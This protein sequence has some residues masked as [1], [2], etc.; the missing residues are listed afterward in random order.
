MNNLNP[1][2]SSLAA[3][4]HHTPVQRPLL[5]PKE[6]EVLDWCTRGKTSP[7]IAIILS[8]SETTINF[9]MANLRIKF[10]V[11][12]RHAAVLKALKLGMTTLP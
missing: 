6:Q 8:K 4:I 5:T 7:E 10:D 2:Q 11:T 3:P 9:H 12:S 1:S